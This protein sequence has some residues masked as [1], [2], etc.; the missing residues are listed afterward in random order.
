[1]KTLV[2]YY[3]FSGKTKK[4]AEK[5]AASLSGEL[6]E[7]TEVKKRNLFTTFFPGCP[8][9]MQRVVPAIRALG[10]KLEDYDRIYIG[11]P[12]WASSPAPA[13][14]AVVSM[15]PAGK[16]VG[17]ASSQCTRRVS[18][19]DLGDLM[20]FAWFRKELSTCPCLQI[21]GMRSLIWFHKVSSSPGCSTF[22]RI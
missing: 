20:R 11:A 4:E 13:F 7:V 18:I 6:C 14:N 17:A 3:S 12:V 8:Q 10:A 5:L 19:P 2:I 1:M 21:V 15:L 22:N 16:E 9:A